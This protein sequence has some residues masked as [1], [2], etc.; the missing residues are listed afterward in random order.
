MLLVAY[1][2][3][4]AFNIGGQTIHSA[5]NINKNSSNYLTEDSANTLRAKLQDL[6][7]LIIDEVSMLSTKL[8]NTI[9]CRLQQIKR[10]TNTSCVF[11]NT[12]ILAVGDF[13]QVPPIQGKSLVSINNTLTDLWSFFSCLEST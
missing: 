6:Q 8:L 13:Y 4:A 5:F 1:I 2:G 3:T 9:H 11:G 7:L 12:A 10:T